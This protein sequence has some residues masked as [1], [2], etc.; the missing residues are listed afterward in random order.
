LFIFFSHCSLCC[1]LCCSFHCP[2]DI[3]FLNFV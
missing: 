2:V 3:V 1:M